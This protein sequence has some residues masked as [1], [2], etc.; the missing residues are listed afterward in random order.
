MDL[1]HLA[2]VWDQWRA[3]VKTA[4]NAVAS[5]ASVFTSLLADTDCYW[6]SAGHS[7]QSKLCYDRPVCRGVKHLSRSH[8]LISITV[9]QLQVCWCGALSLTRGRDCRSQLLLALARAVIL[10]SESSGTH[11]Q[12][13]L[14]QIRDSPNLEGQVPV[15]ISPRNRVA[16]LYPQALGSLFVSPYDSQGYGGVIRT[17]LHTGIN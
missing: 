5:S 2:L 7:K 13:L 16:K 15:F 3:L 4:P 14:S 17:S 12:I 9:R 1:S 8:D 10:G 11:D 6:L